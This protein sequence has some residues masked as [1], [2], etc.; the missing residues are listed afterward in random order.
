MIA[1]GHS[2]QF[3]GDVH[4][5]QRRFHRPRT[6]D[7]KPNLAAPA[8]RSEHGRPDLSGLWTVAQT[9]PP[10]ATGSAVYLTSS[11]AR[12]R[13]HAH[14]GKIRG[15]VYSGL[16]GTIPRTVRIEREG[17][18]LYANGV[19]GERVRLIPHANASF[20]GTDGLSYEFD[21]AGNPA[22]FILER[23]VSGDYRYSRQP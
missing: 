16:W 9:F 5:A 23:H 21:P 19:F 12:S 6:S 22:A 18:T 4:R 20:M 17:E 13:C 3:C 2:H 15:S 7:G 8:P 14:L 1:A 10:L 11:A